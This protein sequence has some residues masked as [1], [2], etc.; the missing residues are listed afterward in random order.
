MPLY[1]ITYEL[2]HIRG[3]TVWARGYVVIEKNDE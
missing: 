1:G 2:E 3:N